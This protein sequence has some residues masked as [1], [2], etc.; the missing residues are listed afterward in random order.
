M[1]SNEI[2]ADT[3]Y[4]P[5]VWITMG[6]EKIIS[7]RQLIM[8]FCRAL[9]NIIDQN[10]SNRTIEMNK[11]IEITKYWLTK[12]ANYNNL[13]KFNYADFQNLDMIDQNPALFHNS[14][15]MKEFD[16]S[17]HGVGWEVYTSQKLEV[18]HCKSLKQ[19]DYYI[20]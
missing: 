11:R 1:K 10:S 7:C 13:V 4:M 12:D 16:T 6:H 20:C 14:F 2:F 17:K 15:L 18:I 3:S 9:I 5:K 8:S 19:F